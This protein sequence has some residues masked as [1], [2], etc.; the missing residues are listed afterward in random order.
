MTLA[1]L[2]TSLALACCALVIACSP[3]EGNIALGTLE[4]DRVALTATANEVLV[5]CRLHK[6]P[7]LKKEPSW[8]SS[9]RES[10]RPSSTRHV[11]RYKRR[12]PI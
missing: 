5:S 8:H 10:S 2:H 9:T 7:S 11:Q 4:R 12:A 1:R 6:G 3:D